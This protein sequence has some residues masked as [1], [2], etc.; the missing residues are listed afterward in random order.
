MRTIYADFNGLSELTDLQRRIMEVVSKWAHQE[1]TPISLV[2]IKTK[3]KEQKIGNPTTINAINGLLRKGY[4][5]RAC[6][7]SNKSYFV[8]LRSI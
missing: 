8:M 6:I 7:I 2:E 5:R 4:L 3:M 1:K